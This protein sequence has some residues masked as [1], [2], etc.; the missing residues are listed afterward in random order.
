MESLK[1]FSPLLKFI[2]FLA[3]RYLIKCCCII[4]IW[5][6]IN[7]EGLSL[8][9]FLEHQVS[10]YGWVIEKGHG[11]GQLITIPQNEF[12]HPASKKNTSDGVPLEHVTRIFPILGWFGRVKTH[13]LGQSFLYLRGW[14]WDCW[15]S[16]LA[17]P[18]EFAE[19][20][21]RIVVYICSEWGHEMLNPF[22]FSKNSFAL[23]Q[24][25][26]FFSSFHSSYA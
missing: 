14:T 4:A 15:A 7:I 5:Q 18:F 20:F 25:I 3:E 1:T 2:A 13:K 17:F 8:D 21:I 16:I 24:K 26:F 10:N 22:L 12:N 6:A 9:K 23:V 11:R 19:F